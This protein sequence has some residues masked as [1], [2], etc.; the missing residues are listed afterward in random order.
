MAEVFVRHTL[1]PHKTV[2]VNLTL[3]EIVPL[4]Y[5][6]ERIWLLEVGTMEPTA[7]GTEMVPRYINKVGDETIEV[8]IEKAISDICSLIDWS[9]FLEDKY[10]PEIVSFIPQGDDVPIKSVVEFV[11]K[12]KLPSAGI[13]LSGLKVVLNNGVVDFDITSEVT[14]KGDPY[15][16]KLRWLP[17]NING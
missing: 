10:A 3:K 7:S 15:E 16:Y 11:V 13:D 5:E 12:D 4:G 14:V 9:D 6:G 17:P 8:E 2:K 1:N